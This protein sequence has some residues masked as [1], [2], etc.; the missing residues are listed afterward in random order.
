MEEQEMTTEEAKASLGIATH[1]QDQMLMSQVPQ[2]EPVEGEMGTEM[3]QGEELS[4]EEDT[5]I[6]PEALKEE[7][8]GDLKKDI[9]EMLKKEIKSLLD[10]DDDEE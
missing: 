2:E 1:L 5:P 8:M 10:E 4:L 3:P 9:K 6:D 7:I